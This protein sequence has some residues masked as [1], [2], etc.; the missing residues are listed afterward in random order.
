M[1]S[2]LIVIIAAMGLASCGKQQAKEEPKPVG[3]K[4][5]GLSVTHWTA[6]TE[7]FMEYPVL[8]AGVGGR[9]AVHFTRLDNFRP[10]K[11]GKVGVR[12]DGP[13]GTETF[14]SSGPSRP[15]IFGV[16]V[17]PSKPGTYNMTVQVQTADL[18]DS[19]EL[20][21]VTVYPDEA[22]AANHPAAKPKEETIAF[23]KEQQWALDFAT[24]P[25]G[26]RTE[27]SSFD[28]PGEVQLRTGGQSEVTAPI[29]GRLADAAAVIIGRPVT[30]GQVLAQIAPPVSAPSDRTA[31]EVAKTEAENSLAF[32]RRD[33]ERAQRLVDAG[34][35]PARR[36]DEA[37]LNESTIEIRLKA[38]N[39][40]LAQY[41]SSRGAESDGGSRL[42]AVRAP[43]TGTII[44]ARGISG[45][46]VRAGDVLFRIVDT[47]SVYVSANVPEAELV[48]LRQVTGAEL[49]T[50]SVPVTKPLGRQI[51]VGRMID[52]Q[53]RTVPVLYE[54]NNA[55]R[56]LVVGQAVQIRLFTSANTKAPAI[57]ESAIVDDAGRPVVFVQLAG[58]AFARRPVTLGNRQGEYIQVATG[59]QPGERVVTKGAYLIRL[60]S[61]SSQIP[62]HGHVH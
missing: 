44:E 23:L 29:D 59:V 58:E 17:K 50:P 34:A 62:A 60:S 35:A 56:Q 14:S 10:M 22:S 25:V 24:E 41:E 12:I 43:I 30:R 48:R 20:G 9:F 11:A 15:G 38:A 18:N 49:L 31:L 42:F 33:R 40:R 39:A 52:P 46:N 32:A 45:S 6:R 13:G 55:D 57:R 36:L 4:P 8:V 47:E 7:L 37:R 27:R 51:S 1:K 2:V 28:V 54:M 21:S 16:D 5:E 26:E 19:H 61:M 3:E 53:S